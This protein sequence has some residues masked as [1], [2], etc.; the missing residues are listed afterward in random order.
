MPPLMEVR[1]AI[2]GVGPRDFWRGATHCCRQTGRLDA[3]AA[4]AADVFAPTASLIATANDQLTDRNRRPSSALSTSIAMGSM[5]TRLVTMIWWCDDSGVHPS[6]R[7][8]RL[9]PGSIT[10]GWR[11]PTGHGNLRR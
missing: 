2:V 11:R 5:S 6:S 9:K 3:P 4:I 1:R 8:F 10:P 7:P